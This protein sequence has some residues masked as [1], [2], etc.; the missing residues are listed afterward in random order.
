MNTPR[1]TLCPP[2]PRPLSID[3]QPVGVAFWALRSSL[4]DWS[5]GP[6]SEWVVD[7][8]CLRSRGTAAS[9][10]SATV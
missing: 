2:G 6:S 5:T 8:G 4:G 3:A 10:S 1:V 9:A 7:G